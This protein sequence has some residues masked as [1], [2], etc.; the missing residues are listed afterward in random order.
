MGRKVSDGKA[1]NRTVPGGHAV[2]DYELYRIGGINGLAIGAVAVGDT[3]RTLAFEADPSAVY[4]IHVPA[5]VNPAEGD[6]L[7]WADPTTF[8]DGAVNLRVTPAHVG[9]APC[10]WVT[11]ARSAD[12]DGGYVLRGRCLNGVT[13]IGVLT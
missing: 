3:V 13:G 4:S 10:F 11:Q 8:Q 7:Y 9:D 6:Y 1:F 12:P 5:G 2:S